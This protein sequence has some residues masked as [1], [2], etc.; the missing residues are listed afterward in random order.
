MKMSVICLYSGKV[1]AGSGIDLDHIT[2]VY[3]EGNLNGRAGLYGSG[4][5]CA[6]SRI[7]LEAGFCLCDLEF[8]EERRLYCE[9][10]TV[11][12]QHLN[13]LWR[14]VGWRRRANYSLAY[15][16]MLLG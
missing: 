7:T 3:E 5:G 12:G 10:A 6:G 4:L 16:G 14:F 8:Y 15:P 11:M 9:D 13:H 1:F 2:L